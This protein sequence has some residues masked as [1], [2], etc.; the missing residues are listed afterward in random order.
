[1][2]IPNQIAPKRMANTIKDAIALAIG[3]AD[4]TV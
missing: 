3:L 2:L 4:K 1:M